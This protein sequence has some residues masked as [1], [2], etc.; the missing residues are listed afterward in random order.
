[1][2]LIMDRCSLGMLKIRKKTYITALFDFLVTLKPKTGSDENVTSY[3]RELTSEARAGEIMLIASVGISK[4]F[5][6]SGA[7]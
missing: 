5:S 3:F 2:Q 7:I 4:R 6:P 1:M